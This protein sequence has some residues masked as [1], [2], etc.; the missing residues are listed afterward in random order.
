MRYRA[1][2]H[3]EMIA[4]IKFLSFL[5]IPFCLLCCLFLIL[6]ETTLHRILDWDTN[7]FGF[8][9]ARVEIMDLS[10][11]TY[12]ELIDGLISANVRLAI[13]FS[14]V[15]Y[16]FDSPVAEIVDTGKRFHFTKT[17]QDVATPNY[18]NIYAFSKLEPVAGMYKL[19][20]MIGESS[21]F[22]KDKR[23]GEFKTNGIYEIWF[24]NSLN[25]KM[26]DKVFVCTHENV[27]VGLV[28]CAKKEGYGT[29][30]LIGTDRRF[31]KQGV[32]SVLLKTAEYWFYQNG[33]K[34]VRIIT[35]V[36]NVGAI[37][38][39]KK[40]GYQIDKVEF[41]YHLWLD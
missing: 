6:A 19:A 37:A 41:T 24:R 26:A 3:P 9:V 35:Q 17:L 14:E 32:G 2:L 34:E 31:Q 29:V 38:L 13:C 27:V 18:K 33:I 7:Y 16:D 8:P 30:G 39:Y 36:D 4:K 22:M 40:N 12:N 25:G 11:G 23:V 1:A 10:Q 21:H 5:L 28:T 15:A 20:R